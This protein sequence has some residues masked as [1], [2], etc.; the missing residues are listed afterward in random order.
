M[1]AR[2]VQLKYDGYPTGRPGG[3]SD[4]DPSKM[5][6]HT[7]HIIKNGFINVDDASHRIAMAERD[8]RGFALTYKVGEKV[9]SGDLY[10]YKTIDQEEK[11]EKTPPKIAEFWEK[12]NVK[13]GVFQAAMV[14]DLT[15]GHLYII[16]M[17]GSPIKEHEFTFSIITEDQI[18]ETQYDKW[19]QPSKIQ[20][21]WK[22]AKPDDLKDDHGHEE[23]EWVEAKDFIFVTIR[24]RPGKLY[25]IPFLTPLWDDLLE[26]QRISYG[27]SIIAIQF[28]VV[29]ILV[30]PKAT[31]PDE[32][33]DI[34]KDFEDHRFSTS[35]LMLEGD[36]EKIMFK[37]EGAQG[38][39]I[40]FP[41]VLGLK[42][43]D[44]CTGSGFP[45]RWFIGSPEGALS[46][47]S[48]DGLATIQRLQEMFKP[49]VKVI[50][51]FNEKF[52]GA[53]PNDLEIGI[54]LKYRVSDIDRA[55]VEALQTDTLFKKAQVVPLKEIYK[56]LY[57]T[58]TISPK[59][60]EYADLPMP[61]ALRILEKEIAE[62][63][64]LPMQMGMEGQNGAEQD[65]LNKVKEKLDS[66]SDYFFMNE[67][68]MGRVTVKKSR[69]MMAQVLDM[70][71][72]EQA[73]TLI[74]EPAL[75]MDSVVE[76]EEYY[77]FEGPLMVPDQPL[78]YPENNTVEVNPKEEIAR[79][80]SKQK[81]QVFDLGVSDIL[82]Q[83]NME[84]PKE[85]PA[86]KFKL[87]GLDSEGRPYVVGIIPKQLASKYPWLEEKLQ[88]K[89]PIMVSAAYESTDVPSQREGITYDHTNLKLYNAVVTHS[90]GKAGE[91]ASI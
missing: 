65:T 28:G 36:P 16:R 59:L 52:V 17:A 30:L 5:L 69:E 76:E 54:R 38:N 40:D 88:K 27:M 6:D 57:P 50:K 48:E 46:A 49:W 77:Q 31:K 11:P 20:L 24:T 62:Q 90:G 43:D 1:K 58:G 39:V 3:G 23:N 32:Y 80:V 2:L 22:K 14:A 45:K 84:S 70:V 71:S 89:A 10:Y 82:N 55:Q 53:E 41:S 51:M 61:L 47:A 79:M 7:R 78:I 33:D 12:Y 72:R 67:H 29:P 42:L 64:N 21:K 87:M 66:I 8:T 26:Y 74:A 75:K 37:L 19:G 25:G 34:L 83:H 81:G 18:Q 91:E 9:W 44:I 4:S 73:L 86:G 35:L 68:N 15:H 56:D 85:R 60:K 63:Y 13:R